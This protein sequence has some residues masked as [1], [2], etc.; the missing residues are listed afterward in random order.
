MKTMKERVK[1]INDTAQ[2]NF[3][4]AEGMLEMFNDIYGTQYGWLNK[5]VVWFEKPEAST[6]EKYK[7]VHDVWVTL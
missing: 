1:E 5:R 6:C 2:E 3:E 4:K 7:N